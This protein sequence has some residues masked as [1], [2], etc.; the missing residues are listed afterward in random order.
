MRQVVSFPLLNVTDPFLPL[1]PLVTP[2]AT[3][4]RLRTT[5]SNSSAPRNEDRARAPP[6]PS[7]ID[8]R[9]RLSSASTAFSS[10]PDIA[11]GLL[12]VSPVGTHTPTLS[13]RSINEAQKEDDQRPTWSPSLS[14]SAGASLPH[15]APQYDATSPT[16]E[17]LGEERIEDLRKKAKESAR[18]AKRTRDGQAEGEISMEEGAAAKKQ[19]LDAPARAQQEQV[20]HLPPLSLPFLD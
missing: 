17:L 20:R 1:Y 4:P 10:P 18:N 12:D 11:L 9:R 16:A 3:L 13:G 15:S 5:S 14:S 2:P 6:T 19:K 7:S 8:G